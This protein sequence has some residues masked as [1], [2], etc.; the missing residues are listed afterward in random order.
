[1]NKQKL[2][3][4]ENNDKMFK[5]KWSSHQRAGKKGST[6]NNNSVIHEFIV[7]LMER[8]CY[9]EFLVLVLRLFFFLPFS[10]IFREKRKEK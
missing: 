4:D 6:N 3:C 10:F 7:D 1:M 2:N 8:Y 9:I 5:R